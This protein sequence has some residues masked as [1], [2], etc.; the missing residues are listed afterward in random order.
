MKN[1]AFLIFILWQ[2]VGLNLRRLRGI[3]F[4]KSYVVWTFCIFVLSNGELWV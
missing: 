1:M 2:I 4:I 3:N